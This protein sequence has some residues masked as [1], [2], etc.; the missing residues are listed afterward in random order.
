[1]ECR[2]GVEEGREGG[3]GTGDLLLSGDLMRVVE[4]D[5]RLLMQASGG[6]FR[7]VVDVERLSTMEGRRRHRQGRK[8][9]HG[10]WAEGVGAQHNT[11]VILEVTN[12]Y[13]GNLSKKTHNR[14]VVKTGT[15]KKKIS[16]P[17]MLPHEHH[18]ETESVPPNPEPRRGPPCKGGHVSSKWST[19]PVSKDLKLQ[20]QLSTQFSAHSQHN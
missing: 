20:V 4:E 17:L 8:G 3:R 10:R 18:S 1:M 12:I 15:Q 11:H 16:K 6:C 14:Y 13:S 7:F 9:L 2:G 5:R 19:V